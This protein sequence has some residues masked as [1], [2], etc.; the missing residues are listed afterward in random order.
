GNLAAGS[1]KF[2]CPIADRRSLEVRSSKIELRSIRKI[3]SNSEQHALSRSDWVPWTAITSS[4]VTNRRR[5][6]A[7]RRL[8]IVV[9]VECQDCLM[10]LPSTCDD[11]ASIADSEHGC[12]K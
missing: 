5:V 2:V 10:H 4:G 3:F 6:T 11:S 12:L 7:A 1:I 8:T 9:G